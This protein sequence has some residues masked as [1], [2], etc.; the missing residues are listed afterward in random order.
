MSYFTYVQPS[1]EDPHTREGGVIQMPMSEFPSAEAK[2][3]HFHFSRGEGA[4]LPLT[5][6]RGGRGVKS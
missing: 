3:L 4:G 5:L 2:L 1:C 6:L